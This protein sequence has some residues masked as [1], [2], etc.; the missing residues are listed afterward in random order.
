MT[1]ESD[2]IIGV[3]H[4]QDVLAIL[5]DVNKVLLIKDS[6]QEEVYAGR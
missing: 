6:L 3:Y 1:N 4:L 5:L 2:Y